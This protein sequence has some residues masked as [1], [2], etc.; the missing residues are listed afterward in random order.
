MNVPK[1]PTNYSLL[2][3]SGSTSNHIYQHFIIILLS[4][5]LTNNKTRKGNCND[6][7]IFSLFPLPLCPCVC[8]CEQY[9]YYLFLL[10]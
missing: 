6:N 3:W 7:K 2:N 4:F 5:C 9:I 10:T 8:M 1:L